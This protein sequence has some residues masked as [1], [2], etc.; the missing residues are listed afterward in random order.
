[1]NGPR[2]IAVRV[3]LS[4]CLLFAAL[5]LPAGLCAQQTSP[6]ELVRSALANQ[7][8]DDSQLHLFTWKVRKPH[9]HGIQEERVVSTPSASINRITLIDGKPLTPAQQLQE[10]ERIRKMIDPEHIRRKQKDQKEDDDRTHKM[11]ATI[12]DAFDFV[13][14]GS[15]A[16]PNGHKLARIKFTARP[17]FNPPNRE[18]MVFTAMQGEILIDETARRL[19][20]IDGTLFKEVN[21]GW[22]ILAKLYPG[23]RFVIEQTQVTPTHWE[24]T[25]TILHFDGKALLFKPI[26][27]D[28]NETSFDF[29]PVP[30]MSI[31]QARDFLYRPASR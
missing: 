2:P 14:L 18:S 19:A 7:M 9:A 29:Q 15:V 26:H 4:S 13:S 21:F 31:D 5:A 24:A 17:G 8:K 27:V 28:D 10:D 12:P 1:M 30:P 23:G 3:L 20:K 6:A 16:A 11:L 22:G 25:R